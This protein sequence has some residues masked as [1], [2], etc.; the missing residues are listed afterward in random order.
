MGS[1]LAFPLAMPLGG[2]SANDVRLTHLGGRVWRLE[3][4]DPDSVTWDAAW[5]IAVDGKHFGTVAGRTSIDIMLEDTGTPVVE[6]IRYPAH[7]G[8]PGFF[9][10]GLFASVTDNAIKV[11]WNPPASVTDV[12]KYRLYFDNG[13]GTVTFDDAGFLGEV[14]EIGASSYEFWT[15]P[16]AAGT[17]KFVVRTVDAAGNESTNT[18]ASSQALTVF[19]STVTAFTLSYDEGTDKATLAWSDPADIGAGDVEIYDNAGNASSLFPD[20][21]TVVATVAAGTETFLTAALTEGVWVFGARVS[22]GTNREV[23]S[24]V[25][26]TIRLDSS[27]DEVSGPPPKPDLEAVTDGDGK[28]RLYGFVNPVGV[29]GKATSVKFYTNDGAGGAVDYATAIATVTLK[30]TPPFLAA[31]FQT[32]AYGETAR[33]FGCRSVT[34]GGVESVNADEVTITPDATEPPQPLSVATTVGRN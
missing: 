10:S 27:A 7:A 26:A 20:Y 14:E 5:I 9:I 4:G 2:C 6:V 21:A 3:W 17:Y 24:T 1:A 15:D 34:S 28:L 18:T 25:T 16:L 8:D 33:V 22:D 19:P 32:I 23:N 12:I 31:D 29:T 11:T 30:Q 13:S